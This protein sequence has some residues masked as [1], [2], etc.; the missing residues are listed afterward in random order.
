MII[1]GDIGIESKL[2][3]EQ[4]GDKQQAKVSLVY[5]GRNVTVVFLNKDKKEYGDYKIE[6]V[7][8]DDAKYMLQ[9]ENSVILRNDIEALNQ[10]NNHVI[11]VE[12]V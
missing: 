4:L 10:E 9:L 7:Y 12:F 5:T 1:Y 3:L 8:I 6:Q 11:V 2:L